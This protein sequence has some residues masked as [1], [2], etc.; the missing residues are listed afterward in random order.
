[1]RSISCGALTRP[2]RLGDSGCPLLCL[3]YAGGG[4][5]AYERWQRLLPESVDPVTLRLPGRESRNSEPLPGDL[6]VLAAELAAELAPFLTGPFA[7]FG[8]S[9]GALLAYEMA[10]ALRAGHDIEPRCLVVSGMPAPALLDAPASR[11]DSDDS[12]LA[13]MMASGADP[14]IG[15]NTE[16]WELI[17][18]IVRSD[19][20]MG[21]SYRYAPVQ[22]LSCPLVAYGATRDAGL[23]LGSLN[24]WR[25]HTTGPFYSRMLPGDHFY[26]NQWPA[27]LAAD[28]TSRLGQY[29]REDNG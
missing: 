28:L 23:D 22:P 9:M 3:P 21:D 24:G 12:A 17:A 7:M 4:T 1:M 15:G 8:H 11:P 29:L 27:I 19:L 20:A 2:S 6:R 18:P 5:R 10:C 16:L 13:A 26:F 25:S 14:A